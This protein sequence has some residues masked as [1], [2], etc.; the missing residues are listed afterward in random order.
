MPAT[1]AAHDVSPP[2]AQPVSAVADLALIVEDDDSVGPLLALLLGKLVHRTHWARSSAEGLRWFEAHRDEVQL[3]V[4][5]CGLPDGHGGT[6][7]HRLR[8]L[9][10]GLPLLVTS[11]RAQPDLVR[12]LAADG[13]VDF[14]PKPF[15]LGELTRRVRTVLATVDRG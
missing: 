2:S 3:A 10:P 12:L 4:M 8:T 11:G 9:R 13:P 1:L 14:L 6:L 5:D 7:A 15:G